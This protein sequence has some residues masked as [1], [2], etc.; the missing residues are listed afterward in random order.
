GLCN[1]DIG[2]L[3][4]SMR[5]ALLVCSVECIT[6]LCCILQRLIDGQRTLEGRALDVLHHQVIRPD[7]VKLADVE[8]VQGPDSPPF[9]LESFAELV[10]GSLDRHDAIEACIPCLVDFTHPAHTNGPENLIGA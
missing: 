7:I 8:M 6:N 2:G 5:D 10:L 3:E 4:V 1:Q 9:T